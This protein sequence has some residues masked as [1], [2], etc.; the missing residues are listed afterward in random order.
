MPLQPALAHEGG[1]AVATPP[2]QL[3]ARGRDR[4]HL[5]HGR[6]D[7]RG[8]QRGGRGDVCAGHAAQPVRRAHVS[9]ELLVLAAA[10]HARVAE[11]RGLGPEQRGGAARLEVVIH[12]GDDGLH[13]RQGRGVGQSGRKKLFLHLSLIFLL[14]PEQIH[15]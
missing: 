2:Q 14:I 10:H 15:S 7:V 8:P 3:P 12:A 5:R 11:A 4:G 6:L 1:L 9:G 13:H